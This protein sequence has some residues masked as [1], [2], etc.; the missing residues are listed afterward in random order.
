[1]SV[2]RRCLFIG[3]VA[4]FMVCL[5]IPFALVESHAGGDFALESDTVVF[6]KNS[7]GSNEW[8]FTAD[9]SVAIKDAVS[10][11]ESIATVTHEQS[12]IIVYPVKEG[13]TTITVTGINDFKFTVNVTV[14]K[15]YFTQ[16][17]KNYLT[18]ENCWY[19]TKK[20]YVG[21][22]S[23]SK[24]TMKIGKTTYKFT[25]GK[26]GRVKIKLKKVYKLNTKIKVTVKYNGYTVAKN[27]TFYPG[28][29]YDEVKASKHKVK[30]LTH[31][32][33]K[34]DIV[35]VIYKKKAYTYKAKKNYDSKDKHIAIKVKKTLKSN[36]TL[37]IKIVNKDKK[38]LLVEKIK[39]NKWRFYQ[40]DEDAD[41]E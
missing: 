20:V 24:G 41:A 6:D 37:K 9:G 32:L 22:Y 7:E 10:A 1:M 30:M 27:F 28:A 3:F 4:L 35:K 12:W 18:L 14:D 34:G 31:N 36:S 19:G 39:L 25:V 5:A 2:F 40:P 15:S 38:T 17:I 29:T 11:D 16:E 13:K 23:G 26:S 21:V 33:H 8:L